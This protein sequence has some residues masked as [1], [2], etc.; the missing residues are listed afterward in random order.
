M[1]HNDT[2]FHVSNRSLKQMY[3]AC[4][5]YESIPTKMHQHQEEYWFFRQCFQ[6]SEVSVKS[7]E[8]R[9]FSWKFYMLVPWQ[10]LDYSVVG[11]FKSTQDDLSFHTAHLADFCMLLQDDLEEVQPPLF[12]QDQSHQFLLP[13]H[14]V[15]SPFFSFSLPSTER[16]K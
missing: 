2:L 8:F 16:R 7:L 1:E 13:C 5:I 11:V 9:K 4:S 10:R 12:F 15:L 14:T 3:S 6:H